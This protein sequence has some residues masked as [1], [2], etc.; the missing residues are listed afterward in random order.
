MGQSG[1]TLTLP[2]FDKPVTKI[3]VIGRVGASSA[4]GQNIFVGDDA[5]STGTT[6]ATG[7][8]TFAIAPDK[9][10]AGTIYS[11]KVT[12][13]HNTQITSIVVHQY[14]EP[15]ATVT[16]NKYGYATYCSTNPIDFSS[17]EGY[18]AWRVSNIA[19]DG[20]ITFTKITEKIKGGQGVLLYN[21]DADGENTSSATIT[22]ADGTTE[23]GSSENL[24]VGKT[25]PTYVADNEYYGLSGNQFVKV[26]AGIIPAGK[27]LL[28]ANLVDGS[29][30]KS[31]NFVFEE[32]TGITR[33][34]TITLDNDAW[35][36]LTGR[37]VAEPTQGIYIHNGK[38]VFIN[39]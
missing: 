37:K 29:N 13:A 16:L 19:A 24:L 5:V 39:K 18:T 33:M 7:K 6:G 32:A 27:A 28:P 4:V 26:N 8:K 22:F 10:A 14:V 21:K 17:T 34:E 11:L 9:Q 3:D 31:L 36:D 25:A 15:T 30:V 35:Y 12:S 23:F 38:K 2:A 1:A 20:T